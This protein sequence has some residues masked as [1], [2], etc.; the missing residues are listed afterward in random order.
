MKTQFKILL[1]MLITSIMSY[2]QRY[3]IVKK[4][5]DVD[6]NSSI[7]LNIENIYVAIEESADG[8]VHFDYS[9]EFDGYSKKDIE[10]KLNEVSAEVSSFDNVV[11]L[12]AKSEHQITFETI[13]FKGDYGISINDSHFNQK[14]DSIIRKSKD[15]LLSEIRR[16]NRLDWSKSPLKYVNDRF[17]KIDKDGNLSNIRKGNMDIMRSQFVIKIPPFVKIHFNG[18]SCGLYFKNDF[19]N[20]IVIKLKS[21]VLKTKALFNSF[22][23]ITIDDANFE[24]ESISGGDYEFTNIRNGKIGRIENVRVKSEFSKIEI[25][26][27]NKGNT[28]TDFNS[29][30]WFYNWSENLER[31]NLYSEYSKIHFFYPKLDYSLKV[32]GNNTKNFVGKNEINMQPTS[33]GEKYNMMFRKAKGDKKFIGD[34]Y[35]DIIHGII[36]SHDDSIKTIKN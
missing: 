7:I 16:E 23:K 20:E 6:K 2:G 30:Y 35:F 24:A 3:Q 15:S 31:F 25:G 18:K 28:I 11:T 5:I 36:Y 9:I 17:K 29:E 22:N 8:K 14:K 33:K 10:K 19:P 13:K 1:L 32:F 26:E 34:I 21:G 4:S 12:M 27:I